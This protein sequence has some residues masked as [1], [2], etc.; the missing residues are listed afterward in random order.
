MTEIDDKLNQVRLELDDGATVMRQATDRIR[1][2]AGT[3][4]RLRAR[5]VI[6]ETRIKKYQATV[7]ECMDEKWTRSAIEKLEDVFWY[8]LGLGDRNK[9]IQLTRKETVDD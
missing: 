2:D 3:I 1:E 5:L 7:D 6:Y 4:E 9:H 8:E